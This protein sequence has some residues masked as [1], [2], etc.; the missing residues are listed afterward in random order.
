M[1]RLTLESL[2][3]AFET[4]LQRFENIEAMLQNLPAGPKSEAAY[5]DIGEASAFLRMARQ[6]L[7]AMTSK[8]EIP[9]RKR[10]GKLLF[11]KDELISWLE[12]GRRKTKM[13]IA[14]ERD[15]FLEKVST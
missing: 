4:L 1:Q 3:A 7:Y 6:T 11:L 2:P 12:S 14:N 9:F 8:N 15:E 13:E 5:L 10:G